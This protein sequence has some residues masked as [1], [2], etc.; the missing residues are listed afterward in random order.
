MLS[1]KVSNN[2]L[3]KTAERAREQIKLYCK[4]EA[5]RPFTLNEDFYSGSRAK[6]EAEITSTQTK[7]SNPPISSV[8]R[9]VRHTNGISQS[10]S[11]NNLAISDEELLRGLRDRG[12][13]VNDTK[14]LSF[15]QEYTE[16]KTEVEVVSHVLAYFELSSK[17]IL[18]VMPMI[19]ETVFAKAF[20]EEL[21]NVFTT[22]LRILDADGA[23]VC[24]KYAKDE[25]EV[26]SRRKELDSRKKTLSEALDIVSRYFK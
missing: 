18:D 19:F 12:Y 14:Q 13:P 20:G 1:R 24:K 8:T 4:M 17:R 26:Q 21:E 7:P 6:Y 10:V 11:A 22:N 16:F 25:P 2:A 23:N 3:E 5:N 15:L 9:T